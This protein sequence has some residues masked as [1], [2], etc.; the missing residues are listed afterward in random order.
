M[1]TQHSLLTYQDGALAPLAIKYGDRLESLTLHQKSQ[2]IASIGEWCADCALEEPC[3][4]CEFS[5]F[6]APELM[7]KFEFNFKDPD[8]IMPLLIAISHQIQ[9]E[10]YAPPTEFDDDEFDLDE[11]LMEDEG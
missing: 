6:L 8:R 5:E 3:N 10:V 1:T 11:L 9:E 7:E 2:L 4:W